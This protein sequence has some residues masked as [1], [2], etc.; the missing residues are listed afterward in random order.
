MDYHGSQIGHLG[1]FFLQLR[2]WDLRPLQ[3]SSSSFLYQKID[4]PEE[5]GGKNL[6]VLRPQIAIPAHQIT[7]HIC[8]QQ[9][10][11]LQTCAN[12]NEFGRTS[13]DIL[14]GFRKENSP[15]RLFAH[16][17]RLRAGEVD[18]HFGGVGPGSCLLGYVGDRNPKTPRF[19]RDCG[20]KPLMWIPKI[21]NSCISKAH[22]ANPPK[23]PGFHRSAVFRQT[24]W[25]LRC[26]PCASWSAR[27]WT[28]GDDER[29]F[30]YKTLVQQVSMVAMRIVVKPY[31]GILTMDDTRSLLCL[32]QFGTSGTCVQQYQWRF[33]A[34][35]F[36]LWTYHRSIW[37]RWNLPRQ[38][39]RFFASWH[40]RV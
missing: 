38:R 34:R 8:M 17:H 27:S 2:S 26:L 10:E 12:F 18:H 3:E 28:G 22:L 40:W 21:N 14:P 6:L 37:G 19:V 24:E 7:Q 16:L 13:N 25:P 5:V 15:R 29:Q 20:N 1:P 31:Q 36:F 35:P 9:H 23:S 32:V 30:F 4:S 11:F 39:R 33:W